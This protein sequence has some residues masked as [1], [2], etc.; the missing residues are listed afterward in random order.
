MVDQFLDHLRTRTHDIVGPHGA[1][2]GEAG[3]GLVPR[4]GLKFDGEDDFVEVRLDALDAGDLPGF[5][6]EAWIAPRTGGTVASALV[7]GA[8]GE[9]EVAFMLAVHSD[10]RLRYHRHGAA[11]PDLFSSAKVSSGRFHHVAVS[12]SPIET[13]LFLDGQQVAHQASGFTFPQAEISLLLGALAE[14]GRPALCYD[15]LIHEVRAWGSA[16][17][18]QEIRHLL[19]Q[20]AGATLQPLGHWRFD[21]GE[22]AAVGDLTEQRRDAL[23]GQ[24]RESTRLG[25]P[26]PDDQRWALLRRRPTVYQRRTLLVRQ[27]ARLSGCQLTVQ[28]QRTALLT[29]PTWMPGNAR[30][31][32]SRIRSCARSPS[33]VPTPPPERGS[34][35]RSSCWSW[36][37]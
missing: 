14:R 16:H 24:G 1:P 25:P 30:S 8:E 22:G 18:A 35:R 34:F 15:G 11:Q 31:A 27:T 7:Q 12:C 2:A 10:G 4:Y 26:G 33:A 29:S 32:L 36:P 13:V 21:R 9:I 28:R 37:V 23:L 6:F 5:T 20:P 19:R 3:F 17:T